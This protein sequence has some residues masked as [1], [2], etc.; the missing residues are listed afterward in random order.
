MRKKVIMVAVYA[1][2]LL[3]AGCKQVDIPVEDLEPTVVYDWMAGESP[4]PNKRM[5]ILRGGLNDEEHAVGPDG[6]YFIPPMTNDSEDYVSVSD[7]SFILFA[8]HGSNALIK[9]CG[10][11]DCTHDNVQ[12]DAYLYRGSEL[13]YYG[14]YLYAVSGEGP[15]SQ[16]T[17][18]VRMASNGRLHETVLDLLQFAKSHGGDFVYCDMITDGYCLFSTHYWKE[19]ESGLVGE[20]LQS[21]KY[22]LDGSMRKPEMMEFGVAYQCGDVVLSI[23]NE[24]RDDNDYR[25]CWNLDLETNTR[26]YLAEHP[27]IPGWFGDKEAY[28]FRDGAIVR[29]TYATGKEEVMANTDLDGRYYAFVFPDCIVLA[30]RDDSAEADNHLYF[31]NW[32]FELVDTV[33]IAYPHSCRAEFLIIAESAERIVLTDRAADGTP[34]YYI[35]K[36]ELGTGNA[37]VY[38]YDLSAVS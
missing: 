21:Y 22:K 13:S 29:L 36:S 30:S 12:C 4:I 8:E 16:E 9:L 23:S 7:D 38:Q 28:Y 17:K 37:K 10:R 5:G 26:T 11:A 19:T 6:I 15:H 2:L 14:G 34:K 3:L 1:G 31:Y 24:I 18:L 20:R 27:R 33:E 35:E 25:S 32:A